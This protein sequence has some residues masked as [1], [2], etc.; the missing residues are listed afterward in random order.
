M[1]KKILVV[2]DDK[3]ILDVIKY[4]LKDEGYSVVA[5]TTADALLKLNSIKPDLILLDCCLKEGYGDDLCRE[6]KSDPL[7]KHIPVVLVSGLNGLEFIASQCHADAFVE[8]PF[9]LDQLT[10]VV[11]RYCQSVHSN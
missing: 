10:A 9:E 2:D 6:I 3:D 11:K 4:V 7:H 1:S 5:S 8:K